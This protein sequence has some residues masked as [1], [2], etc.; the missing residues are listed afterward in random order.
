MCGILKNRIK[1]Q[2]RYFASE[3]F[4]AFKK[5]KLQPICGIQDMDKCD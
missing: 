4:S 1:C 5:E 3:I 2:L